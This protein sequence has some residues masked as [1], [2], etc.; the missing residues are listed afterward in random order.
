[1][2]SIDECLEAASELHFDKHT[3]DAALQFLDGISVVFYFPEVLEG[4]LFSN[5]QVLLDKATEL[6]EKIHCLRKVTTSGCDLAVSGEW[7]AFKDHACFTLEFLHHEAFQKHYVP[8]LFTPVELIK[9]FRRLLIVAEFSETHYFMPSLLEVLE[10]EKVCE[11]RVAGD[12][13]A[14]ALALD[15]PLGGPRL[16]VYCTLTCY[17]VSPN[18]GHPCPWEIELLPR[19]NTPACLYRNCIQFSV[20]GYPG[21]VTLID[22]FTHFEVHVVTASKVCNKLCSFIHQAILTGLKKAMLT[23]S[24]TDSAPSLAVVCPCGVGVSHV[25]TMGDGLWTC[26]RDRKKWGDLN[27]S[28]FVWQEDSIPRQS[29]EFCVLAFMC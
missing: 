27:A 17:L 4:V 24:Y 21:C 2:L 1:M 7:Q 16:G 14:A 22:T 13:P 5:P 20:P 9:L 10:D 29:S 6:V 12:S 18:N 15:F 28:H 8:C 3:L 26:K 25:A 23:L 19:S 11:H